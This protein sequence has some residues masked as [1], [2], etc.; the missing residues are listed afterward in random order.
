MSLRGTM[1]E[2]QQTH[3]TSNNT[4]RQQIRPRTTENTIRTGIAAL[5]Q[6]TTR[7]GHAS[8][9]RTSCKQRDE[10]KQKERNQTT[11]DNLQHNHP[12]GDV[13]S[14][15]KQ[16]NI[17]RIYYQN[18]NGAST[19]EWM[20]WERA[21]KTTVAK[22]IDITGY[23]ETNVHWTTNLHN[24]AIKL[25]KRYQQQTRLTTSCSSEM[26]T[27]MFQSG[28]TATSVHNKWIGRIKTQIEDTSGMGRWSGFHLAGA[29]DHDIAVITAYRPTLSAQEVNT[30]YMQLWKIMRGKSQTTDPRQQFLDDLAQEIR[31]WK[32]RQSEVILMIDLNDTI[33]ITET[34]L[35]DFLT[36]TG[37]AP[38]H[39]SFPEA[40]Y[41]RGTR[42]IDYIMGTELVREHTT[43]A[44]YLSFYNGLWPSDH[45]GVFIDLDVSFSFGSKTDEMQQQRQRMLSSK[46][47][48]QVT[49]FIEHI[50]LDGRLASILKELEDLENF[51]I[52]TPADHEWFEKQDQAFTDLLLKAEEKCKMPHAASWNPELHQAYLIHKYWSIH[53]R[54][55]ANNINAK[56][57][58]KQ[59]KRQIKSDLFMGD[60]QRPPKYQLKHAKNKLHEIRQQSITKRNEHLTLQQEILVMEHKK[61]RADAIRTIQKAERRRRCFAKFKLHLK[62]HAN[63]G[64]IMHVIDKNQQIISDKNE[65]ETA[66]YERNIHHFAQA[67][68]T[69][70]ASAN[71]RE[72][73]GF[74]GVNDNGKK[75]LDGIASNDEL[76]VT[77]KLILT[78]LKRARPELPSTISFDAMIKGFGKWR[79][80]TTTS[81]SGKHLGIYKTLVTIHKLYQR[82]QKSKTLENP[83]D[84]TA[85]KALMIQHKII[86]LA[87]DRQHT[88]KRWTVVHN[89]FLEKTPGKPLIDKLRVIHIYEADWNLI[90]KYF[91]AFRTNNIAC[92][93]QTVSQE[94][95]GGRPG[96][97]AIDTATKT[98]L[99]HAICQLQRL[100]GAV[101]YNDAKACFDRIIENFSNL[102]CIREG[103]PS[104]IASLHAQT[105]EKIKY[106]VKTKFGGNLSHFLDRVKAQPIPW[107]DGGS[108]AISSSRHTTRCHTRNR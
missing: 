41:Q 25:L 9:S 36:R 65:L 77:M 87:I 45:R 86:T 108:S 22:Q 70:F 64:G 18:I 3:P 71:M 23:V 79:E 1:D 52:W 100:E 61:L 6:W 98:V 30:N 17:M 27:R 57:T 90:L 97:S 21:A 58:L 81:P 11:P 105:L 48:K 14:K 73:L 106:Y 91:V 53:Q 12:T 15:S 95:A 37:L 85:T 19:N 68:D 42:C 28:G 54:S 20:D 51:D 13:M 49:K 46:N 26:G 63:A 16:D 43:A 60:A 82:Q 5:R 40:T 83:P 101:L 29:Q 67:K 88:L 93:K 66:L 62:P 94:Q 99:H 75:I 32:N 24:Y 4:S 33:T 38:I 59:L 50:K 103:M 102:C 7:P 2:G 80:Q 104:Q 76:P 72:K 96:R 92:Q 10:T 44:G 78:E 107:Q 47:L 31:K 74:S 89:L 34:H 35:M 69:P 84:D 55:S 56:R 39:H 8:N